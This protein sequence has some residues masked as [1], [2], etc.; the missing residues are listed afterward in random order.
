MTRSY[1]II[2]VYLAA[3]FSLHAENDGWQ[4][5]FN[6]KNLKGWTQING[7]AEYYV[8]NGEIV[9]ETVSGSTNSFLCTNENYGDFILEFE[10]LLEA[11]INSGVQIRSASNEDYRN[12][13][14]HGYQVE[15]DPLERRWTAGIYDEARRGWLYNLERN[16][17]AR[18]AFRM[19]EWN[20]F[21]VEAVGN[22]IRTWVNNIQCAN[23]VDEMTP[24]G[25]IGLQVHNINRK[26]LEGKKIRWRHIRIMTGDI[27]SSRMKPD[28]E[29]PEISYLDN[30]LTA[31][32]VSE[33]WELLWDG[34][35]A[36]GW[37]GVRLDGF[38]VEGWEIK[39]GVLT[40]LESGGSESGKG[41]DIITTR[42]YGNFILKVD[43]MITKGANSGIKYFVDPELNKGPGSAIGCE[44]QIL[45][46]KNHPDTEKGVKGNRKLGALYD[47]IPVETP[48]RL[49]NYLFNGTGNWNRALIIV[50]GCRVRH[51][52][53]NIKVVDY[54]RC[55]QMWRDLVA[56]SKYKDWPD[57]GEAK[58]GYILLQDHGNTVSFKNIKLLE[59][60]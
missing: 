8:E 60:D 30:K 20:R 5:L 1:L 3:T 44:F 50:K 48:E 33:G 32:E 23:L 12:G 24:S 59:L 47:L 29:V 14:V 43:F 25:F 35:T 53:N 55:S 31:R 39:D 4:E 11:P 27:E 10:V 16:P 21:R 17:K 49:K 42:K 52:L 54:E 45:D 18:E 51:Y 13:R 57:F 34:K 37:R 15:I 40:V 38:P 2:A 46:N 9:G 41:G 28:P 56:G 6:G 58:E 19:G 22:S 7:K 26:E 36:N